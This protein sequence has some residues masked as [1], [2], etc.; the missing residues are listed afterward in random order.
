MDYF[1]EL[2]ALAD[3]AVAA[4]GYKMLGRKLLVGESRGH[5]FL[6][7]SGWVVNPGITV[8][9]NGIRIVNLYLLIILKYVS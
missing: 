3:G 5:K 2:D 8:L 4:G 1:C 7:T 9:H 6:R